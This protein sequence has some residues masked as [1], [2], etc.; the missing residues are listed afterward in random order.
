[1]VD[2]VTAGPLVDGAG[3][4]YVII[5]NLLNASWNQALS[6]KASQAAALSTAQTTF[7]DLTNS[8]HVTAGSV[9][10]VAVT[11]PTVNIPATANT[12]DIMSV[13]D[14]KYLE[15]VALLSDKF[16]AF[17]SEYFPDESNAYTAA[18]DWLQAAMMN[19]GIP[20]TVQEQILGD[21]EARI[22]AD[23]ARASD[24][25]IDQ[26]AARGFPL[27]P[28]VAASMVLQIQQKA[29]DEVAESSRKI[30]IMS[31]EN[32]KFVIEKVLGLRQSA[33]D[34]AI[35][36]ISALASGPEMASKVIGIGYD[37]QSKLIS[38]A[39]Q[40]YGARIQAAELTNRVNQFNTSTSLEA[41]TKNQMADL[42]LI[43]DNVKALL[44]AS[45]SF[46]Q[47]AT[48]LFNNLHV[49]AS[50]SGNT[51]NSVGFNYSNDTASAAPTVT[52]VG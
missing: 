28:D 14:T 27:P 12:T 40:F 15:L 41:A 2:I 38:A 31:V 13:F 32:I 30:A 26:F 3:S 4:P 36:Y 49:S 22:L 6:E 20:L 45:A 19:G 5:P 25:V 29:Q 39:S 9:T 52:S 8:P 48:A 1:M 50:V 42:S 18:E 34:A 35:K 21:D 23:A 10:P 11:E 47:T 7:L 43:Q 17:R 24:A 44:A 16:V 37:A 46:A 51:S 33:M